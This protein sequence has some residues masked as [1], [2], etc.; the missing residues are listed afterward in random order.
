MS[1]SQKLLWGMAVG[2]VLLGIGGAI[3]RG[4]WGVSH[5][6]RSWASSHGY[7]LVHDDWWAKNRGCV[8]QT[9]GGEQVVHS[10]DFGNKATGWVW[11]FAI[12][13]AGALPAAAMVALTVRRTGEM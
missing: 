4:Y 3:A 7:Q 8:A 9:P 11:Q 1:M 10:E 12:L 2:A 6:C 5:D 13:V